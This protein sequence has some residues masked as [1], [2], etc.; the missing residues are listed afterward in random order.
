MYLFWCDQNFKT[1]KPKML[2]N[3]KNQ[4]KAARPQLIITALLSVN[5]GGIQACTGLRLSN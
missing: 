4:F 3:N 5:W 1:Q 2:T